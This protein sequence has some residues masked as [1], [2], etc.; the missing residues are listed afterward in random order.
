MSIPYEAPLIRIRDALEQAARHC[1]FR[2]TALHEEILGETADAVLAGAARMAREVLSPLNRV[3]DAQ[4]AR[5]SSA[6]VITAAGFAAAW[7]KFCAD[8]WP[9]LAAP[10]A[11][12]GQALP[13]LIA[14]ATTEI[15]GGANLA[16][17]M[18]PE[19]SVG[20]IEVLAVHGDAELRRRYIPPL[21]SGEWTAAMSLTEPQAGS[22][23]STVR[24]LARPAGDSWL[25]FGRKIYISWGEHDM[26]DNIV[27]L[28]L[29][30]TPDAPPGVKGLSLFLVPR[31]LQENGAW[32][33]NDLSAASL[34]H[35]MGI[36][37]SPTCAMVLGENLGARGWLVGKL[38][39]GLG[40]MFTLMNHMRI[41]V[42]LHS[43]G[44]AERARQL[45]LAYAAERRQGRDAN[46]AQRPIIEHAD[47]RRMLLTMNVLTH[48][49]RCL[50]YCAAAA[51]DLVHAA[52]TPVPVREQAERRLGL[53]TPLVKA[54][55][56][57]VAVE[58]SS[59]GVQVHGGTGYVD[60]CE[61]SQ[62]YRDA[63]IGPVFEGTN[64]IQAQDLLGRKILRDQARG[65]GELLRQIEVAA[66]GLAGSHALR[67]GLLSECGSLRECVQQLLGAGSA[68]SGLVASIAYPFLQWLGVV[69]GGWQWALAAHTASVRAPAS[70]ATHATLDHAEFYAAHILPR[71][72]AF[73]AVVS[74][75]SDIIGRAQL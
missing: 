7:Q 38:H 3:G 9:A 18:L 28:V 8:G 51:L 1:G 57:D 30:R 5:L 44:V 34:E 67:E 71:A 59:L 62:I 45:A 58:V 53:L 54:W 41:G 11:W 14:A 21:V 16:F 74:G 20:A 22:D 27:H 50:A 40:C 24:T 4:G 10:A 49:A 61:A 15:W 47:V 37:A 68:Q 23:L 32:R 48:A 65:F 36:R 12:D 64:F 43:T 17:A 73:A 39:D 42:G 35:K 26:A 75:G 70:A 52:E 19:T 60:D 55:A 29:A 72:R 31:R 25:L 13:M 63:R 6:G 46:G 56:S 2:P 33:A 66:Q 69:A